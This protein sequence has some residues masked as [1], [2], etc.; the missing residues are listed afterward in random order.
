MCVAPNQWLGISVSQFRNE[1]R[2][3]ACFDPGGVLFRDKFVFDLIGRR[4]DSY[5][6]DGATGGVVMIEAFAIVLR[7]IGLAVLAAHALDAIG[8]AGRHRSPTRVRQLAS[9]NQSL[10]MET[11]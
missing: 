8:T 5:P 11:A 3:A 2:R 9:G 1:R 6:Q 7:L 4:R 10:R